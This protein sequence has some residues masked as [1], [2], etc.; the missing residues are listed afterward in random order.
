MIQPD[1]RDREIAALRDKLS[2]LSEASLRINESLDV[3]AA[4]QG[5]MDGAR[6]VTRAPYAL[7]TTLD[8]S[9]QVEDYLILGMNFGDA[10][11]LWQAPEGP[12]FF[13]YLNAL[14]GSLR[15]GELEN[16]TRSIGLLEFRSPVTFTA[17][18]GAPIVHRGVRVG[19]IYVGSDEPGREFTQEDEETLVLFASQAAQVIANAR[20]HRDERRARA[21]LETLI[22]TSP[23]GVAVF[24]M[25]N[26]APVSFNRE[27]RRIVDG[28]REPDQTP[29]Q[30]LEL[31]TVQ[32]ADGREIS[33]EEFPL[34]Q[35][36]STTETV[37]AEEIVMGAPNGRSIT[38]LLNATPIRSEE[39]EVESVVVTLQD[40]TPLEETERLR[41]EFLGMVSHELRTPLTSIMGSAVAILD[42]SSDLDPAEMRQFLRI[43]VDQAHNMRD[44]IGDLLDVARIET[45]TLPANLEPAEVAALVDRARNTFLSAGG[46]NNLDIDIAPDLPLVM[47]DRRRIVQV[48]GNLLSNAARHSPESSVIRVA[49]VRD[50]IHVEVS[51]VD[52]GRGLPAERLPHLFRKFSRADDDLGGDTGLG[53]AICKGIV[54]AHGGRI[55]AESEGPGLG[56]R[57]AFTVPAVE[58]VGAGRVRPAPDLR[59]EA[60]AGQPIL[61]VDDDPQ[62]LRYVRKALS[63]AGYDPIVTADPEE[64][65]PLV[66]KKR[67]HLVLLDLMLRGADGIE[68][69]RDILGVA[70]V[71]VIFLSAYGRD[72]VVARAFESGAADYIVKPFS[73][74]ELIARV[75][76][77]LR[78][79]AGPYRSVPSEPYV[80]GDLTI[81]YAE[82]LVTLAGRPVQLRAKEYQLIFELSVSAGRVLTHNELL[83]RIWGPNKPGDLRA[84]RTHLRR[85]R[86]KLGEDASN[87]TYFF[88]E[89]RVGYRMA[90]G[91]GPEQVEE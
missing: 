60:T 7:I 29:E 56:A 27:A 39:G 66:D 59:Q 54:E 12:R 14:S 17:F 58:E 77:A 80:L 36:L 75:R 67:P 89:P 30:L 3:E 24:D 13:E 69:M 61:V 20:R 70:D 63:D 84:L 10:E 47:A 45:G 31:I 83:R 2:K 6:S 38:V 18:M 71:P 28:L 11:R 76:A 9:G 48:I 64:V 19:N 37:R 53:L 4:L 26:G 42:A 41:A 68:L 90:K 51:L 74:T 35:V 46:R 91:E 40:M 50:G 5:V 16:F 49:A 21:D 43:I 34:A 23:V 15:G 55:W 73:P 33:L 78:R 25:R 8:A 85:L 57:F 88:A 32:R 52:E 62:T 22:D 65:L 87:P 1:E 79:G 81:D 82:R 44:L 86:Q 72:Q